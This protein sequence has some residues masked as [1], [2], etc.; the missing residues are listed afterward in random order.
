MSTVTPITFASLGV[1]DFI[2]RALEQRGIIEPF[3]IQA[4]TIADVLSGRDVCGRAPTGSGKTLAFGVPMVAT[5]SAAGRAAPG[6]PKALILAPTRELAEQ[7]TNELRSFGGRLRIDAVYGGVGYGPQLNALKR[8]IDILVA[9]PGRL[10]DLIERRDVNLSDVSIVVLDEADR[11]ADMGFMPS[12][13]RLLDRTAKNRQTVLFS[14]TLDG[15]IAKLT[16]EYQTDPVRHEVGESTPDIKAAEHRFWKVDKTGRTTVTASIVQ[17]SW[18]SIIFTR[19]RHGADRLAKQLAASGVLTAPIHGGRSQGQR[20]KALEDFTKGRVHALV[21]TD[22]A[23]RGIHVD[24]VNSVIHFDP[25]E[26]HKAYVHRSGRTARAGESGLVVSLISNDQVKDARKMQRDIGLDQPFTEPDIRNLPEA[27]LA[28]DRQLNAAAPTRH[29][30]AGSDR[31]GGGANR[32][33]K[34]HGRP[35]RSGQ[36]RLDG[37]P[38]P[39]RSDRDGEFRR[40]EQSR[41]SFPRSGGGGAGAGARKPSGGGYRGN[42]PR[43]AGTG[44]G[45]P[46]TGR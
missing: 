21:A 27:T 46:R 16:K 4:V 31:N 33:R 18:P 28:G 20:N 45:R 36:P 7:I 3:E 5:L 23:A 37:T 38:R 8:G 40:D 26:D 15:D 22:V 2:C 42:N 17:A 19:T 39:E 24:G 32:P 1:P 29:I 11:M 30:D 13:R 41:T 9:C 43:N 14:A 12:V 10:E 25:P 6:R 35:P 44:A 34:Q